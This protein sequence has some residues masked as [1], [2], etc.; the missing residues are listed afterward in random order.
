MGV[1]V[2]I[3]ICQICG[4]EFQLEMCKD[5]RAGGY[6]EGDASMQ[7]SYEGDYVEDCDYDK[8]CPSCLSTISN[9]V[10]VVIHEIKEQHKNT[11]KRKSKR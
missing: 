11:P 5:R 8:V 4:A 2:T 9:R 7:L 10:R 6:T 1:P 3:E